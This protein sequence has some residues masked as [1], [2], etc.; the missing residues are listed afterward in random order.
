MK[1]NKIINAF[2]YLI[3]DY[4]C[5]LTFEENRGNHYSFQNETF[6]LKRTI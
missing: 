4:D 6:K 5:S 3:S 1:K 2:N